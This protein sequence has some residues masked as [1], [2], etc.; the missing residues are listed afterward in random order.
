MKN[1]KMFAAVFFGVV[2]IIAGAS[3]YFT[4]MIP[5]TQPYAD[6][7]YQEQMEKGTVNKVNRIRFIEESMEYIVDAIPYTTG[8]YV[9]T[10]DAEALAQN[11][12]LM[13]S[14]AAFFQYYE[15][16]PESKSLRE[17]AKYYEEYIEAM[18]YVSENLHGAEHMDETK[19]AYLQTHWDKMIEPAK[20]MEFE[21]GKLQYEQ[22]VEFRSKLESAWY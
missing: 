5:K 10:L 20:E 14:V 2:L 1:N 19:A 16:D 7:V 4:G 11:V 6:R 17:V 8:S 9:Q 12:K 22:A 3:V 13:N 15:D 18:K 21:V